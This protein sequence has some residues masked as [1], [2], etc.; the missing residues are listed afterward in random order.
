MRT[1]A[2]VALADIHRSRIGNAA[3]EPV[4]K[5]HEYHRRRNR[6]TRSRPLPWPTRGVVDQT[7]NIA[8]FTKTIYKNWEE[9]AFLDARHQIRGRRLSTRRKSRDG[10]NDR[11]KQEKWTAQEERQRR[12]DASRGRVR[13]DK[14]GNIDKMKRI[15]ER[16]KK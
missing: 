7:A 9:A 13:K 14:E 10:Y 8:R 6:A 4:Q 12:T 1:R 16:N 5:T 15:G 3:Q 2:C 11:S